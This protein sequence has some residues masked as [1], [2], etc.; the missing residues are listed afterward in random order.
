MMA[1][2]AR[3]RRPDKQPEEKE[4]SVSVTFA[5]AFTSEASWSDK[6]SLL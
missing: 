3:N 4:T 6:V 1:T 2:T 5:K